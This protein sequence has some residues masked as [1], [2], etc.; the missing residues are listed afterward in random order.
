MP[1]EYS[2]AALEMWARKTSPGF[3]KAVGGLL[4]ALRDGVQA[5]QLDLSYPYVFSQS[6][7]LGPNSRQT[8]TINL[9][10][11]GQVDNWQ[12]YTTPEGQ[13]QDTNIRQGVV[14][15]QVGAVQMFQSLDNSIPSPFIALGFP[16]GLAGAMA[17]VFGGWLPSNTRGN[18]RRIPVSKNDTIQVTVVNQSDTDTYKTYF[19]AEQYRYA[20]SG[21]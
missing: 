15:V 13:P 8:M 3:V 2:L 19:I 7:V 4:G 18:L 17:N 9:D 20:D 11:D 5:A 21:L 6:I 10:T 16:T 14:R 1:A 12:W